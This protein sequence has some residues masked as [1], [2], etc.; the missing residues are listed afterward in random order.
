MRLR[1]FILASALCLPAAGIAQQSPPPSSVPAL[2]GVLQG[3]V[4]EDDVT[5]LF[6]YFRSALAAASQGREPP[7]MPDELRSR[8]EMLGADLRLRGAVAGQLLLKSLEAQL[9]ELMRERPAAPPHPPSNSPYER[10]SSAS[11]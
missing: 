8:M 10:S 5:A 9:K 3:L 1:H 11:L 2:P 6:D 7:P 4:S